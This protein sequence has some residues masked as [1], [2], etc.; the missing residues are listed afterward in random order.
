MNAGLWLC[1]TAEAARDDNNAKLVAASTEL[2][3][4]RT[5]YEL[6]H[7][8]WLAS[9]E[10][11]KAH[12]QVLARLDNMYSILTPTLSCRNSSNCICHVSCT[13]VPVLQSKEA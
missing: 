9:Q 8:D 4:R 10:D 2:R 5:A 13:P 11:L 3:A 12:R 7:T 1:R 6:L